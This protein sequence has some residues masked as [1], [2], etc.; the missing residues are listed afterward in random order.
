VKKMTINPHYSYT[1][2][3]LMQPVYCTVCRQHI[4]KAISNAGSGVCPDCRA[5]AD[6]QQGSAEP[7]AQHEQIDLQSS[8]YQGNNL[9]LMWII[10]TLFLFSGVAL[11]LFLD[12]KVYGIIMLLLSFSNFVLGIACLS[13]RKAIDEINQEVAK[14]GSH[15]LKYVSPACAILYF[16]PRQ[17]LVLLIR[18]PQRVCVEL[19]PDE[20]TEIELHRDTVVTTTSKKSGRM[21]SALLGGVILGPVGAIAGASGSK[22]T[23]STSE[24]KTVSGTIVVKTNSMQNPVISMTMPPQEATEWAQRISLFAD[25][26]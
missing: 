21:G 18:K 16:E 8:D 5:G 13:D 1:Q 4:P 6:A 14:Y 23:S 26:Q 10:A 22:T 9:T 2:D 7:Q 11:Y 17:Q 24:T 3:D 20:I 12:Y 25:L 15:T 19:S